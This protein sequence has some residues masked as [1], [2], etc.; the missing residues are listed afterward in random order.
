MIDVTVLFLEGGHASTAVGPLE[1][2]R[3]AG[4]LW[5]QLLG[6]P[7]QPAFFRSIFKR[8]TGLAPVAYKKKFG[9]AR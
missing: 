2:F 9:E 6:A 5:N 8:H 7:E 3:D 1:V 4:R